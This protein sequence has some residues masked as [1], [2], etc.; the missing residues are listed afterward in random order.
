LDLIF[1]LKKEI[2]KVRSSGILI[3]LFLRIAAFA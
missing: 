2:A 1:D 3:Q